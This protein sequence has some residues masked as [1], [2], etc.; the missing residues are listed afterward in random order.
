MKKSVYRDMYEKENCICVHVY[1]GITSRCVS[2][3]QAYELAKRYRIPNVIVIWQLEKWC[4]IKYEDVFAKE[5]F[6]D[7]N[8]AVLN[9]KFF[10]PDWGDGVKSYLRKGQIAK[11]VSCLGQWA[12]YF[13]RACYN[14]KAERLMDYFKQNDTYVR[15]DPDENIGWEGKAYEEWGLTC[16]RRVKGYLE[17]RVNFCAGIYCGMMRGE[18][19]ENRGD[20]SAIIFDRKYTEVANSVILSGGGVNWIGVH[21]R[22]TDHNDS[23]RE[24]TIDC[25][26]EKMKAAVEG[27]QDVR[28]FLAT[29]DKEVE[30]ELCEAF[31]ERVFTYRNK[32]WGRNSRS[33]MESA[34]VD[35]LC[36]SRCRYILGSFNSVFS[37]F[38]AEYGNTELVVCRK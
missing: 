14:R 19:L 23:I 25:F 28:F 36:L 26:T 2:L 37:S 34:V 9:Y 22:R 4:N 35:F 29:D 18:D 20:P 6:P 33:G 5:Q 21:V 27:N 31:P 12:L 15:Y 1:S 38:A 7:V 11:V 32:V 30:R 24:S 17:N 8:L 13:A 3:I 16:W 10:P